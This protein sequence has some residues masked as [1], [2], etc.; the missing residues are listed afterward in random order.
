MGS[1]RVV[2][3]LVS[4][5]TLTYIGQHCRTTCNYFDIDPKAIAATCVSPSDLCTRKRIRECPHKEKSGSN[6]VLLL[7]WE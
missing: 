4:H 5:K 2:S 1:A 3:L 6:L 7:L